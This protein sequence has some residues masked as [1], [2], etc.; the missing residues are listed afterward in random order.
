[1]NDI[2]LL[3]YEGDIEWRQTEKGIEIELPGER[4]NE[5]AVVFKLVTEGASALVN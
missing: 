3:G 2:S 1:V 4:I 5:M